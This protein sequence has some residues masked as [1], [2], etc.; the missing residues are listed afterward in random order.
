MILL[1]S[2]AG[3]KK[4]GGKIFHQRIVY[5]KKSRQPHHE[6]D[7]IDEIMTRY[8]NAVTVVTL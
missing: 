1:L 8:G 2:M 6:S 7:K 4:V 5:T 3:V